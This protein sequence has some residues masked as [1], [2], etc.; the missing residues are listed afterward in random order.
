MKVKQVVTQ[1]E[2]Q[3]MIDH[4][5]EADKLLLVPPVPRATPR[6]SWLNLKT[7]AT[8][9]GSRKGAS[10]HL[11]EHA[12]AIYESQFLEEKKDETL[13]LPEIDAGGPT[14]TN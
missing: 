10:G 7:R 9:L 11:T 14:G 1:D 8:H 12:D 2:I 13:R 6:L 5:K 4:P 3:Y